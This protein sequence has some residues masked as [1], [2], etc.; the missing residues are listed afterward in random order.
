MSKRYFI[1]IFEREEDILGVTREV[2]RRGL[3]IYDVFTPYAVHGLDQAMGLR[4]SRIP[5]VCLILGLTGAVAKLWFQI[6]TS[7]QSWPVN[8][9]GKPLESVPAFVPVTFEITVLFAGVGT[10]LFFFLRSKLFPGKKTRIVFNGIT[11]N[12]FALVLEESNAAFDV[13]AVTELC[14]SFHAVHVE[15]RLEGE[16]GPFDIGKSSPVP[17]RKTNGQPVDK[18]LLVKQSLA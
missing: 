7:A 17:M 3:T 14:Q 15:E 18:E 4:R 9:G 13:A 6:W 16:T 5:I 12:R 11:D 1:G 10:V 2:R 8:V